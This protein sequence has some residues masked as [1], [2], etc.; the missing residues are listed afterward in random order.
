MTIA[1][2][3]YSKAKKFDLLSELMPLMK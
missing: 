2:I 1:G 3:I